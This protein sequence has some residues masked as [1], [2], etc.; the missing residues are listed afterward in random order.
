MGFSHMYN[1]DGLSNMLVFQSHVLEVTPSVGTVVRT[2]I[3]RTGS[4]KEPLITQVQFPS[5]LVVTSS[6]WSPPTAL[7][8]NV[9]SST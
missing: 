5:Q 7:W 9:C 1:L 4:G 8:R 6:P 3:P 2:S